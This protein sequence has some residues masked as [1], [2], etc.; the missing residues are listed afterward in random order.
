MVT[1]DITLW[2][3][4]LLQGGVRIIDQKHSTVI[5]I[6]LLRDVRNNLYFDVSLFVFEQESEFL[7]P[8]LY[9]LDILWE[10]LHRVHH[11]ELGLQCIIDAQDP[12]I[13]ILVLLWV[14]VYGKVQV[15]VLEQVQLL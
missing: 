12:M 3:S 4:D 5:I 2:L 10:T 9:F 13:P 7:Q 15:S 11:V 1:Q 6:A 14:G 8:Q